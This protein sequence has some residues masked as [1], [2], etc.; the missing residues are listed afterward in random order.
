MLPH[1]LMNG[2]VLE[3]KSL[4]QY[5]SPKWLKAR[6]KVAGYRSAK[7]VG[8]IAREMARIFDGQAIFGIGRYVSIKITK[9]IAVLAESEQKKIA[10]Q[11]SMSETVQQ[12]KEQVMNLA[13]DLLRP[14]DTI[15]I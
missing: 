13:V 4:R 8:T 15:L 12:I 2:S 3:Q 9:L 10:E 14:D 11:Q 1:V 5:R 6:A 7:T